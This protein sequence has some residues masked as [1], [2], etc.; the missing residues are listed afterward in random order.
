MNSF[1]DIAG[2][3]SEDHRG[4]GFQ[5]AGISKPVPEDER[6]F[7]SAC[8]LL[9]EDNKSQAVKTLDEVIRKYPGVRDA[10]FLLGALQI[11]KGQWDSAIMN[12]MHFTG[13]E[14]FVGY[15][16]LKYIP[17][18][19]LH[20]MVDP[21]FWMPI[22]PRTEEI[23][24]A[25]ALISR[26]RSDEKNSYALIK[27]SQSIHPVHVGLKVLLASMELEKERPEEAIRI[28]SATLS[29]RQD[30]L[31]VMYRFIKGLAL[32]KKNDDR[33][34]FFQMESALDFTGYA[35]E[36][37][38]QNV[39]YRIIEECISR[40]YYKDAIKHLEL[41]KTDEATIIPSD[42]DPQTVIGQLREKIRSFKERGIDAKFS[43]MDRQPKRKPGDNFLEVDE[44]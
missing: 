27:K 28:L 37:L 13:K 20:M 23:L 6:L 35:S 17:N 12:L 38:K 44:P 32:V 9:A 5:K 33:S 34:G 4:V 29:K 22:L 36:Y 40:K 39:R 26:Y 1:P 19:R 18:F 2:K 24:I 11:C 21:M 10:R 31:S 43:V 16:I 3:Y 15:R 8:T 7:A 14:Y 30:D 41:L 25:I 42:F